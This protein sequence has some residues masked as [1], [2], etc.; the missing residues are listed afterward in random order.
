MFDCL[1]CRKLNVF[2]QCVPVDVIPI[3]ESAPARELHEVDSVEKLCDW[4]HSAYAARCEGKTFGI[5]SVLLL[6]APA[7]GKS[8]LTSQMVMYTLR[9]TTSAKQSSALSPPPLIPIFVRV[10]T[11]QRQL[12]DAQS[13]GA[14]RSTWNWVDAHVQLLYGKESTRYQL[15]R[16]AMM[17][18]RALILIDGLDEGGKTRDQ[19]VR[20][21]NEVLAPQGH[22]ILATGR[23]ASVDPKPFNEHFFVIKINPLTEEQQADVIRKR[24]GADF[25]MADAVI[26]YVR[27]TVKIDPAT[28]SRL[29]ANP[30]LLSMVI[31]IAQSR[32]R[33]GL[34]TSQ[35]PQTSAEIYQLA[36]KV[37]NK[38]LGSKDR[39]SAKA[40]DTTLL[41]PL[42]QGVFY[43]A[44]C[45]EERVLVEEHLQRASISLADTTAL[46][47]LLA[48]RG[49]RSSRGH[50]SGKVG[51]FVMVVR[52]QH[53][54]RCGVLY[55][56]TPVYKVRAR[57]GDK[58]P[59]RVL[60][61]E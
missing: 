8:C 23:P 24:L 52:G 48:P 37:M 27:T 39:R 19:I 32:L 22:L 5:A 30:L 13:C 3:E 7:A 26:Q 18:R 12:L 38:R 1:A 15:L 4:Y 36:A 43:Q 25:K 29:T 57:V 14:F 60:P 6:A 55:G 33:Y 35:L 50:E 11:L 44:H 47:A 21:V 58:P 34:D 46:D 54:G 41:E 17:T 28:K 59:S 45:C 61:W 42:I 56:V 40:K 31:T 16:Q 53:A 10:Q 51:D 2:E 20:H 49:F 9:K